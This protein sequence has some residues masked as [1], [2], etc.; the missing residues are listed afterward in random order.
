MTVSSYKRLCSLTTVVSTLPFHLFITLLLIE[1]KA[2]PSATIG[3]PATLEPADNV[4]V[5][6]LLITTI[7]ILVQT[8]SEIKSHEYDCVYIVTV[9][10]HADWLLMWLGSQRHLIA[11]CSRDPLDPSGVPLSFWG[12]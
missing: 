3:S 7:F 9:V 5:R 10:Q 2:L 12:T 11:P 6:V 8:V 4:Y 1:D